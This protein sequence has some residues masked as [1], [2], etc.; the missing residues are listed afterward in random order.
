MGRAWR[1][2]MTVVVFLAV[3]GIVLIGAA[4]LT[5]ASPVRIVELV[6]GG[7]AGLETWWNAAMNAA[8]SVWESV[9]GFFVGPF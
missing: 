9:T 8:R 1:I 4:W 3:A 6:F 5:G 7:R 2:I